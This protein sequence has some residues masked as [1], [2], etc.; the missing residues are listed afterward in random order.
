MGVATSSCCTTET[1]SARKPPSPVVGTG[2]G[3]G[4]AP[5]RHHDNRRHARSCDHTSTQPGVGRPSTRLSDNL[6]ATVP[7]CLTTAHRSTAYAATQFSA[8]HS[9]PS[10]LHAARESCT[11]SARPRINGTAAQQIVKDAKPLGVAY[12]RC[13]LTRDSIQ[14]CPSVAPKLLPDRICYCKAAELRSSNASE[15]DLLAICRL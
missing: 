11:P 12:S 2:E 1:S 7:V 14:P 5:G 3:P 4:G 6:R 9:P 10:C 8:A 15:Q 13:R